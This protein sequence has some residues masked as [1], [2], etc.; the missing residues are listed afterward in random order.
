MRR[1]KMPERGPWE[2]SGGAESPPPEAEEHLAEGRFRE[3]A[4]VFLAGSEGASG[5]DRCDLLRRA[6]SAFWKSGD[7]GRAADVYETAATCSREAGDR[8]SEA[9]CLLG[10]GA[11]FH[12]MG[13]MARAYQVIYE[14]L[15]AAEEVGSDRGIADATNWLGIVSRSQED[16]ALAVEH[17]RR[18]L[19]RSRRSGD[20]DRESSSLNSLGL[21]LH[22]M[23]DLD[24]ALESFR[25][26]LEIRLEIKDAWGASDTLS[27]MGMTLKDMGRLD[28]ALDYYGRSLKTRRRIGGDSRLAN[29][30]N[31]IGN[32]LLRM[33]RLQ[34]AVEKHQDALRIR[35]RINHAKGIASSLL[36]L[37]E[38]WSVMQRPERA[39]LCLRASLDIQRS[40]DMPDI[41][42]QTLRMLCSVLEAA[43][44]PVEALQSAREAL[45]TSRKHYAS[46]ERRKLAQA[47]AL[48]ETEHQAR[49]ARALRR[50]NE[51]LKELSDMLAA[52]KEQLQLLLDYVPAVIVFRDSGGRVAR[53]NRYAADLLGA[54]PREL[55]GE[56]YSALF[57]GMGLQCS[58]E[59]GRVVSGGEPLLDLERKVI[60]DGSERHFVMN[61]VPYRD[62]EGGVYGVV[63]FAVDVTAEREAGE[64]YRQ[65]REYRERSRRLESLSHLAGT[66]AHDFNNLLLG[67]MGNVELASMKMPHSP[68]SENL[69]IVL[70]SSQRAA[71]LC[72]QMLAFSGKGKFV[73]S[74]MDLSELIREIVDSESFPVPGM[75]LELDE[76]LPPVELDRS[77]LRQALENLVEEALRRHVAPKALRLRT[78]LCGGP[79][80]KA[81][82]GGPRD[83]AYVCAELFCGGLR[84]EPAQARRL[85]E[86]FLEEDTAGTGLWMPAVAGIVRAHGGYVDID[87]HAPGGSSFRLCF[88][89][90]LEAAPAVGEPSALPLQPAEGGA[91]LVVDDEATVRETAR[92]MIERL[93]Y[94]ALTGAGGREAL[95]I[96]ASGESGV[97]C[98][99]LD[100]TMPGMGGQEVLQRISRD[101]PGMRVILSSGFSRN[102][103]ED[104]VRNPCY[105]GFL[106]KPYSSSELEK[107]LRE[108]LS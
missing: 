89:P 30:L 65:L 35:R 98:V 46:R 66:V 12:G 100:L 93:G 104:C 75:S 34:E 76:D 43:G 19:R 6:A 70:K 40:M 62:L 85:L 31:N 107:V 18:A 73:T 105:C 64:R 22:H 41:R 32:L 81:E 39:L 53:L 26:S 94:R 23:G 57:G 67:I 56:D 29:V 2:G 108:I 25:H 47:R 77:Q 50:K 92:E 103:A 99:L 37:G 48:L 88:P 84:L 74:R 3:A 15:E 9:K 7:Y 87:V 4:E 106:H 13:S 52:K 96:L 5:K 69:A 86:P 72:R 78:C 24:Q 10:L 59:S 49:E 8:S 54:A 95:E 71:E 21:A 68:A 36:N 27:N 16:Y 11:S 44:R 101:H 60:M 51:R 90:S 45:E 80:E 38:A 82:S 33:G 14:A 28:E 91:V 102:S 1:G 83:G 63:V 79:G 17:H 55:V 42:V 97:S 58:E 61:L 20:S